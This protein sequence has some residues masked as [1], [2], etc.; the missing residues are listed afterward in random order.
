MNDKPSLLAEAAKNPVTRRHFLRRAG[1]AGAVGASAPAAAAFLMD[2]PNAKAVPATDLDAAVLNFALNLEYLEGQYYCYAATG[3]DLTTNGAEVYGTGT[4]GEV[5]IR[6]APQVPWSNPLIQQYANEIA[7]DELTHVNFLRSALYE[8]GLPYYAQPTLDLYN[9]FNTLAAAAGIG[10]SFDP[11]AS[12]ANFLLGAFIFEDVGVTAYHGAAPLITSPDYLLAAAGILAVEAY[13][14]G[15]LRTTLFAMSQQANS[16]A[17]YGIDIVAAVTAITNLR[18]KLSGGSS[19]ASGNAITGTQTDQSIVVNNSA[20]LT[21]TDANSLAFARNTREV[22][23]IVYGA[24]G[25]SKGLFFPNGMSG[26]IT[27]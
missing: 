11:F 12:D 10:S 1:I 19:D 3:N 13:H 5:I 15:I 21:P 7:A 18:N 26:L 22:L 27:S 23:N 16:A 8:A 9:S 14:A 4:Q 20:N 6:P 2:Q 25:A 17:I 24:V